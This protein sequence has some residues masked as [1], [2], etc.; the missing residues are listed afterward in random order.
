MNALF[1][2]GG[3]N[4]L[5]YAVGLYFD[6]ASES[7]FNRL[8]GQIAEGGV[9]DYM[10]EHRIAPHITL[11]YVSAEGAG[12]LIEVLDKNIAGIHQG[13]IF[14]GSIGTFVPHVVYAAPVLNE[15]LHRLNVQI[16]DLLRPVSEIPHGGGAYYLP[17]QWVPHTALAVKMNQDELR[18]AFSVIVNEFAAFGG[19]AEKLFL[20]E[21]NPFKGVRTWGLAGS[22]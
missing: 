21:C 15:Y 9:N 7:K 3:G 6:E 17:Y 16:N 13:E 5:E 20:A 18:T 19:V 22:G 14:W 11:A 12:A 1:S 10:L 2:L 4:I 8:I